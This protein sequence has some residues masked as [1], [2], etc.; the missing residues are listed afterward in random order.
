MGQERITI[1]LVHMHKNAA[2]VCTGLPISTA[3]FRRLSRRNPLRWRPKKR[4]R[5]PQ[6]PMWR[7]STM[8][9]GLKGGQSVSF[10]PSAQAPV[11]G[12]YGFIDPPHD[13]ILY[14]G[15]AAYTMRS[16]TAWVYITGR[17]ISLHCTPFCEMNTK[18]LPSTT[19]PFGARDAVPRGTS[20]I[21][22]IL[23]RQAQAA[24]APLSSSSGPTRCGLCS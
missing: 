10:D 13:A 23:S 7:C 5:R 21:D 6:E 12:K 24:R 2:L 20:N 22:R 4:Y 18:P 17:L 14:I 11:D 8:R 3:P 15:Y 19:A 9:P 1:F 16:S